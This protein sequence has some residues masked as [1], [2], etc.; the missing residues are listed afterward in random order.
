MV[1]VEQHGV[2]ALAAAHLLHIAGVAAQTVRRGELHHI[3]DGV[4]LVRVTHL[5]QELAGHPLQHVGIAV[6]KG[7]ASRNLEGGAG[8]LFQANQ[9]LLDRRSQLARAQ[10]Q[11]GRLAVEGV[12]DVAR[13]A[14]QPVMQREKGSGR[15]AGR[16]RSHGGLVGRGLVKLIPPL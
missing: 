6:A 14:G 4:L 15:D 11:G 1:E 5:V 2:T 12:D 7:L 8:A 3:T 10:G 9:A 16:E 13:G